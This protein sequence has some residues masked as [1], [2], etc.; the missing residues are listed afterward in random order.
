[1]GMPAPALKFLL[2]VFEVLVDLGRVVQVEDDGAVDLRTLE[3]RE[4]F[5]NGRRQP[6]LTISWPGSHRP[7]RKPMGV[8]CEV[9][10]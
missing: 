7:W 8:G 1:M 9:V 6:A 5:L 3:R 2:S 10:P 4:V